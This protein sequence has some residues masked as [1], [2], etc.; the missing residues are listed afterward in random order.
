MMPSAVA[1]NHKLPLTTER[2][3][4]AC[5]Q[6]FDWSVTTG[7]SRLTISWKHS[8][9]QSP[10]KEKDELLALTKASKGISLQLPTIAGQ[11][12]EEIK[13]CDTIRRTYNSFPIQ[14]AL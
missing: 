12:N 1:Y 6:F 13:V 10:P 14:N 5:I 9:I 8:I 2:R 4:I 11:I 7:R 3:E